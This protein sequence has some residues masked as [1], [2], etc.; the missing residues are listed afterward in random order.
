MNF[1]TMNKQRK[2]V[3][4]ASA[5]GVISMFLPWVS[6]PFLGSVN[7]MHGSGIFI[8]LCFVVAGIITLLGDQTKNFDTS[9][10]T[11]TLVTGAIPILII[12]YYL[13]D[14]SGNTIFGSVIGFGVY[15]GG[16]AAIGVLASAYIF[17]SP[18]DNL[19]DT[20]NTMKKNIESKIN[21]HD[22][23]TT[24][25]TTPDNSNSSLTNTNPPA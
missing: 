6:I 2:F 11:I 12:L 17:R 16:L 3:L 19:K 18:T 24:G 1:Q 7:G 21:T 20:F 13:I 9:M 23:T 14:A 5:I 4:I 25:S 15:I 10:W 8:F 22:N